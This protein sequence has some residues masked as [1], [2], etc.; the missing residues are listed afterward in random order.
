MARKL[1]EITAKFYGWVDDDGPVLSADDDAEGIR[2]VCESIVRESVGGMVLSVTP[3]S[4]QFNCPV[5][6]EDWTDVEDP[7]DVFRGRLA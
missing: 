4:P 1:I 2:R 5:T 7:D 6:P 3:L